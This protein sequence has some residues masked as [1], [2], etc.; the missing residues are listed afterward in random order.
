MIKISAVTSIDPIV[1]AVV[2]KQQLV[3]SSG[4]GFLSL[5]GLSESSLRMK[6]KNALFHWCVWH[7]VI[8]TFVARGYVFDTE[9]L[10]AIRR[11][12]VCI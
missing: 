3:Q 4:M 5:A 7:M 12:G 9:Q 10:T 2:L 6:N 1:I 11:R 8:Y